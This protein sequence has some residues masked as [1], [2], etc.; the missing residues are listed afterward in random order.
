MTGEKGKVYLVGAGPGDP[1]L[2]TLRAKALLNECD[3]LL[4]DNLTNPEIREWTRLDCEHVNV[5][6]SPGKHSIE[7]DKI[8]EILVDKANENL[9]VVRLKG[10]DPFVFARC[11]EEM[12][13]LDQAGIKYEIVPGVTAALACAAYAGVPL[14]HREFGS[15][16]SFLTGHEDL[17]K[18]SLRV[19]F[20]K[21]A[22][23]GGTLCIYMG[24]SKLEEIVDRLLQGGL[25][26]EKPTIV[27]SNGTLPTQRKIMCSLGELVA[28]TREEGLAAPA[29]IFIGNAIGLATKANWF[30]D[31]PLFGRRFV[32]TRSTAQNGEMRNKLQNLGA[33]VL[34]LPLI[35]I[36]PTEDKKLVAEVFAGIA[37]YEWGVFTSAN[38]ARE[39][40]RIFF[41]AF[42][43]IRSFGPMRIACVGEATASIFRKHNLEVELVPE[44][45]TAENLAKALVAT[46]SLDSANVLVVSGNRNREVMVN[47][48]ETMGHAIVDIL[49]VYGTDFADVVNSPDL[50]R[51]KKGGAD[52]IIFSSSSTALSFVE[53][54]EDLMLESEA[55]VPIHCSFGPETSKTLL[56][57]GLTVELECTNPSIDDML[58]ELVQYF[59]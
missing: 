32:V 48:L 46:D 50:E 7:Q 41:K 26:P 49:P 30:E 37:T 22:E 6:K 18:E 2:L 17:K 55:R 28:K 8:S 13:V 54:E 56:E 53:Q 33:D 23:V 35:R 3:V 34:E 10:G 42:K 16:I 1:L 24:M 43:D 45:A 29:V 11:A 40:L 12:S 58:G 47:M 15:S 51:Y 9:M 27:V 14:S 5:G 25:S 57:N 59:S 52:G 36:L 31:R 44:T 38:G 4:Y 21:F 20:A 19:D 39:F